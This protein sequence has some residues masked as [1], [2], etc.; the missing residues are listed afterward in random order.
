WTKLSYVLHHAQGSAEPG[1]NAKVGK[2]VLS[3]SPSNSSS[4]LSSPSSSLSLST[5]VPPL[6]I[7]VLLTIP[8][9]NTNQVLA[10]L[11]DS[12]SSTSTRNRVLPTPK[13]VLLKKWVLEFTPRNAT[14][15]T[16]DR[17]E[18]GER[19]QTRKRQVQQS[20]VVLSTICKH[21][22]LFRSLFWLSRI[23]PT[24]K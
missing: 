16:R 10:Y 18:M 17:I 9:L 24:W 1:P 11:P 12:S 19:V 23:L 7:Q 8:D 15:R 13:H 14:H 2:W 6:E 5:S 4:S 22:P 20:S 3:F 21:I